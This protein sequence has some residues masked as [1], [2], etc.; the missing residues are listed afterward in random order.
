[1]TAGELHRPGDTGPKESA[2]PDISAIAWALAL[3]I[4]VGAALVQGSVGMGFAMVSV[5]ALAL[6][7]PQLSP[8]PQLLVSIPLAITMAWRERGHM[9]TKGVGWI[10]AGRVPGAL[11]GVALLTVA[12]QQVLD[13]AIAFIVLGGVAILASGYHV[14]RTPGT[15]F[16]AGVTSG[17]SGLVASIGGPPLA[18]L[19]SRAEG[20]I[21]RS[22]LAAVFTIGLLITL[23]ARS[24]TGNITTTDV[25]V[26]AILFPALV[27][28]YLLSNLVKNRLDPSKLRV[29]IL[30]LSAIA[31]GGL[32]FRAFT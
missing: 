29:A 7:D 17:T 15:K 26:A 21:I 16:A 18:L 23:I 5:P 4:T 10:I 24:A 27:V 3:V 28:G 13:I 11:I 32:L 25:K 20:G 19:Y 2:V 6:I 30:V 22:S 9:D 8:V 12:T 1:M 31:A 14:R